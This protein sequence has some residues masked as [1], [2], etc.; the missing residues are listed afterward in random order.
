LFFS[1]SVWLYWSKL[2]SGQKEKTRWKDCASGPV[3][4]MIAF[5]RYPRISADTIAVW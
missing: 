5:Y 2:R 3:A 4:W 1:S